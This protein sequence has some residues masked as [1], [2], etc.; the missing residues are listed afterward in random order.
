MSNAASAR[1]TEFA[2]A[3]AALS[4]GGRVSTDAAQG[5]TGAQRAGVL[6]LSLGDK[7]SARIW[8]MLD[9]DEIRQLS[10]AMSQLGNI[11]PEV[12]EGLLLEFIGRLSSAGGLMGNFDATER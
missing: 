10:I 7:V 12:V 2:S 11:G 9:D 6:M 1:E 3:L 5:L 8:K 4:G